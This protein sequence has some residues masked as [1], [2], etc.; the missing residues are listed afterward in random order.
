M[1]VG[2]IHHTA[3]VTVVLANVF[4]QF[5]G[6]RKPLMKNR[7]VSPQPRTIAFFVFRKVTD[8]WQEE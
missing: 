2:Q 1:F 4:S 3:V 8:I 7:E 6:D 5:H